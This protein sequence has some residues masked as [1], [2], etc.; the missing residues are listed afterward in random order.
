LFASLLILGEEW[1]A[2]FGGQYKL[3]AQN[4]RRQKDSSQLYLVAK[5][6][7]DVLNYLY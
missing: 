7:S 1:F 5:N 3:I 6:L 4:P 2:D